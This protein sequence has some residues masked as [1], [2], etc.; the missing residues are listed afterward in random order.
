RRGHRDMYVRSS[1]G[2]GQ[3]RA[4]LESNSEKTVLDWAPDGKRMLY[5]VLNP[6]TSADLWTLPLAG[7]V[8]TPELFLGT[9]AFEDNGQVSPDGSWVLYRSSETGRPAL[10]VQPLPPNGQ[11]WVIS[12][13]PVVDFQWR[14]DGREILYVSR[15]SMYSVD[16]QVAGASL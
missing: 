7:D 8:R 11:K 1:S 4:L 5:V 3:E 10:Y 9:P 13:G 16:V 2:T 12:N 6:A 14:A 15:S